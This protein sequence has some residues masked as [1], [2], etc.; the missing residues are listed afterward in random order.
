MLP[1]LADTIQMARLCNWVTG[2]RVRGLPC[3]CH[4]G[5]DV[6]ELEAVEK[7]RAERG[8]LHCHSVQLSKKVD[9]RIEQWG[10]RSSGVRGAPVVRGAPPRESC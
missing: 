3:D 4:F 1:T 5:Q 10:D 7:K 2:Y 9:G 8:D 6:A